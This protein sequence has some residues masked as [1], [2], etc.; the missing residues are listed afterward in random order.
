[1]LLKPCFLA[2]ALTLALPAFAQ[3]AEPSDAGDC[4]AQEAA[5]ESDMDLARSRG[6]ML[7]R[8]QLAEALSALQARCNATAPSKAA[9]IEKLEQEIKT[10]RSELERAEE[11]LR[12]LKNESP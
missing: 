1:M 5:L 2:L 12:S 6:Q 9:R 8:R 4:K 11:Q 10:L 3:S 7:R